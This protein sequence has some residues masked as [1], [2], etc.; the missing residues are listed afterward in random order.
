MTNTYLATLTPYHTT[1]AVNILLTTKNRQQVRADFAS[2]PSPENGQR[3]RCKILSLE[4][5]GRGSKTYQWQGMEGVG[6]VPEPRQTHAVKASPASLR[7]APSGDCM[8][9]AWKGLGRSNG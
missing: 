6:I 8:S 2:P 3:R 1:R 4:P 7:C 9:V 5:L